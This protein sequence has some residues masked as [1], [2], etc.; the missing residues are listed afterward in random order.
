MSASQ[1]KGIALMFS[2]VRLILRTISNLFPLLD[3]GL[4]DQVADVCHLLP[5]LEE[6]L[7]EVE[8]LAGVGAG[9]HQTPYVHVAQVTLLMLCSYVA[10]WWRWGPEGQLEG[11]VFTNVIPQNASDLI[12]HI[13]RITYNHVGANQGDW[14]KQIAGVL[15]LYNAVLLYSKKHSLIVTSVF[16]ILVFSQPIICKARSEL[17]KSHFLPLMEK[18]RK[19]TE[20]VLIEEEQLKAEGCCISEKELQIEETYRILVRDLYAFYPLL[21]QFVDL[22][23]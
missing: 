22:N 4:P 20:C 2:L 5:S 14:M 6:A 1:I 10:H 7:K 3:H 12:G 9:A 16:L 11:P 21:I 15:I 17:L 8:E 18:L 23:R 19:R 13:L